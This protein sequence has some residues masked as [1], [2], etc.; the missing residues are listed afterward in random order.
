MMSCV[1]QR[2]LNV[3]IRLNPP[4]GSSFYRDESDD[5]QHLNYTT[6]AIAFKSVVASLPRVNG[7]NMYLQ[8]GHLMPRDARM[9]CSVFD[10]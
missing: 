8:V 5:A 10:H 2:N 6:L 7:R 4:W 3:V 9:E 1:V